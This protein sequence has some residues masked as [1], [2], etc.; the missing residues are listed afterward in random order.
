MTIEDLERELK[1]IDPN[2]CVMKL[3]SAKHNVI[4]YVKADD[5]DLIYDIDTGNRL[6]V[7]PEPICPFWKEIR[8]LTFVFNHSSKEMHITDLKKIDE[9]ISQ[10][11]KDYDMEINIPIGTRGKASDFWDSYSRD[12]LKKYNFVMITMIRL[13]DDTDFRALAK[14]K[15]GYIALKY[16]DIVTYVGDE[17]WS[18]SK[19]K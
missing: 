9:R 8:L 2:L 1:K 10:I 12:F 13:D 5:T 6:G 3:F 4:A 18:V 11:R 19:D 15:Y 16:D 17:I 7:V 14:T